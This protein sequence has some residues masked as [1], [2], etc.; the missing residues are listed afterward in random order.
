MAKADISAGYCC[1]IWAETARA[2][3]GALPHQKKTFFQSADARHTIFNAVID[4]DS[5]KMLVL[6]PDVVGAGTR[7]TKGNSGG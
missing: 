2:E 5:V 6:T 3:K 4:D 1:R 7:R